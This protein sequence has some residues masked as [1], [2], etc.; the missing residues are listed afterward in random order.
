MASDLNRCEF[1]GRLSRDAELKTL[2]SGKQMATFSIAINESW[3]DFSGQKEK[4]TEWVN[5]VAYGKLAEICGKYLGK[6]FQVYIAGKLSTNKYQGKDGTEKTSVQIVL[7]HL[8]ML[9]GS[10]KKSTECQSEEQI[11]K[12]ADE[13]FD[14]SIPF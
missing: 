3:T 9:Q 10:H 4:K 6:G 5:V 2:K 1:I 8:Q 7:D 11:N 12:D 14:D 13:F